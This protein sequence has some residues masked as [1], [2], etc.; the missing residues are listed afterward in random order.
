MAEGRYSVMRFR[1]KSK[2]I[3]SGR[4]RPTNKPQGPD[5]VPQTARRSREHRAT[6][7]MDDTYYEEFEKEE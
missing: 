5:D 4:F 7:V 1:L 6:R 3:R 2:A